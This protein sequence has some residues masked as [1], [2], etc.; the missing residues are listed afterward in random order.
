MAKELTAERRRRAW[1]TPEAG[2]AGRKTG[3][4][5]ANARALALAP[6]I[7]EIQTD[8]VTRPHAIAVALTH[9]G[10]P[11][12]LGHRSWTGNTVRQVLDRLARLAP[13][14]RAEIAV[15]PKPKRA[16]KSLIDTNE[17]TL[18]KVNATTGA[19]Q[20]RLRGKPTAIGIV[21]QTLS[22]MRMEGASLHESRA[23]LAKMV[24]A[25]NGTTLGD[26]SWDKTTILQHIRKWLRENPDPND[27]RI[28][29][30]LKEAARKSG[31]KREMLDIAISCGVLSAHRCGARTLV[32]QSDLERFVARLG[33]GARPSIDVAESEA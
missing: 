9:R 21:C 20:V 11:T 10:V 17:T 8:G 13:S 24:A 3:I 27:Y 25:R 28:A 29:L 15:A 16:V 6:L 19:S 2:E 14:A 12:A 7:A 26:R 1:V 33:S 4:A 22:Q 18:P 31:I 32:L 5:R 30:T 23:V